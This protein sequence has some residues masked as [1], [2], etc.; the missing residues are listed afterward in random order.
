MYSLV[1]GRYK[2]IHSVLNT[3]RPHSYTGCNGN[4][5][6]STRIRQ[7]KAIKAPVEPVKTRLPAKTKVVEPLIKVTKVA[8]PPTPPPPK[9]PLSEPTPL[10]RVRASKV[11]AQ[12]LPVEKPNWVKEFRASIG[13]EAPGPSMADELSA[14]KFEVEALKA[15]V[16]RLNTELVVY[17]LF[18]VSRVDRS[19]FDWVPWE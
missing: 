17:K 13:R 11:K 7:K 9:R 8:S 3:N 5:I 1:H 10:V 4:V 12:Q 15:E 18:P 2:C 16:Q 14:Y 19:R 6:Y